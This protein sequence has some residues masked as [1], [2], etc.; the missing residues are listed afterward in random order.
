[1][2]EHFE[3]GT[4]HFLDRFALT[5]R[6]EEN[7]EKLLADY[8]MDAMEF[9]QTA[10]LHGNGSMVARLR[11]VASKDSLPALMV[12]FAPDYVVYREKKPPALFFMDAKASITPVFFGAQINRILQ[13]SN[14]PGLRR[15][16]IG[17]IEREA[18]FSYNTFWP[19]AE[20]AIIVACP[21]NT[22]LILAEWVKNIRCLW[23]YKAPGPIPWECSKCPRHSSKGFGVVVNQLAGGS[24]TPHTNLDFRSMRTLPEFLQAEF[25]VQVNMKEYQYTMLDFVKKW[26]LNKTTG[27]VTWAQYNGAIREL[28][29]EGCDWLKFRFEDKFFDSYEEFAA[30]RRGQKPREQKPPAEAPD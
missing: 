9:G 5:R 24:G 22:R 8:G 16:H 12:K 4:S 21:Y 3:T 20:V 26:P 14:Q 27:T 19:P 13:H 7:L 15:S 23:C 25:G 1:M 29:M 30:F 17:E 2:Q 10:L 6:F 11:R 18:W 28:K